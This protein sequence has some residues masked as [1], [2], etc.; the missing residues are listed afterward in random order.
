VLHEFVPANSRYAPFLA[1]A[2]HSSRQHEHR[3][4]V[5]RESKL[6]VETRERE[7]AQN[8]IDVPDFLFFGSLKL[9]PRRR[10]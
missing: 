8:G 2:S 4:T 3:P 10:V 5:A 6:D 1:I 9:P 7:V